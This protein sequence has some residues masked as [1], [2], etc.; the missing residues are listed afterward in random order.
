LWFDQGCEWDGSHLHGLLSQSIEQFAARFRGAA[1]EPEREFVQV[2]VQ[3][4]CSDRALVS[5]QQPSLQQRDHAMCA[6]KQVFLLRLMALH[7]AIMD[8]AIQS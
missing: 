6:R 1:V 3:M 4:P 7:L 8:V 5:A 2:I